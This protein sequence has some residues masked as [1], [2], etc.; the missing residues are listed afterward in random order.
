MIPRRGSS[1]IGMCSSLLETEVTR[2]SMLTDCSTSSIT[3]RELA[4]RTSVL[5]CPMRDPAVVVCPSS[6]KK[7]VSA[8][9]VMAR[10]CL[11]WVV[12]SVT[13]GLTTDCVMLGSVSS[14]LGI[15]S[16]P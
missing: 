1:K 13:I 2:L 6:E 10:L 8:S 15:W 12:I 14:M 7:Y 4:K 11:T 5:A 9:G 3:I 16:T